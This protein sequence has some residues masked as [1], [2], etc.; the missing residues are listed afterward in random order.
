VVSFTPRPLYP[1]DHWLRGWV[2][3]RAGGESDSKM[4]GIVIEYTAISVRCLT[5]RSL[6]LPL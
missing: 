4:T 1:R 3:P 5:L 2:G 6:F